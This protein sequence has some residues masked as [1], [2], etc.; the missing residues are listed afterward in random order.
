MSRAHPG[1]PGKPTINDVARAAGVSRA[2]VSR[3]LL[4]GELEFGFRQRYPLELVLRE[5]TLGRSAQTP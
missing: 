1:R 2:T 4:N 3:L 5:S